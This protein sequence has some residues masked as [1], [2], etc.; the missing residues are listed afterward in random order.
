MTPRQLLDLVLVNV[1]ICVFECV[2]LSV[3]VCVCV[4]AR[5]RGMFPSTHVC[6]Y[7]HSKTVGLS[8]C[9][10]HFKPQTHWPLVLKE[11]KQRQFQ[12]QEFSTE[13]AVT[14]TLGLTPQGPP[15]GWKV[16]SCANL[17]WV[18][19]L[20]TS[21][22]TSTTSLACELQPH[23]TSVLVQ[24]TITTVAV[25]ML[26]EL[27]TLKVFWLSNWKLSVTPVILPLYMTWCGLVSPLGTLNRRYVAETNLKSPV[28]QRK[29]NIINTFISLRSQKQKSMF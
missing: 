9:V 21:P 16:K 18:K 4:W 25:L 13:E 22:S 24:E 7:V 23:L 19:M 11:I 26:Q 5:N 1:C 27:Q 10:T 14:L 28:L 3:C 8:G 6:D 29:S 12:I 15:S 20:A 17:E 2:R